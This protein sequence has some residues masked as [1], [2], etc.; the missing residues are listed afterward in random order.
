MLKVAIPRACIWQ[1]EGSLW[2]RKR[3]FFGAFPTSKLPPSKT[4]S[5]E[6]APP[7]KRA[8]PLPASN[9]PADSVELPA[10]TR[11]GRDGDTPSCHDV[12][13]RRKKSLA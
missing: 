9:S 3:E 7:A 6:T 4:D 10:L 11:N 5:E 12:L 1:H 13:E 8:C 2:P